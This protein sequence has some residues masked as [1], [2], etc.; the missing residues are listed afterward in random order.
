MKKSTKQGLKM[1]GWGAAGAL[2]LNTIGALVVLI[3][4]RRR[5]STVD[6]RSQATRDVNFEGRFLR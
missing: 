5:R 6:P 3:A 2:A 4:A 1:F